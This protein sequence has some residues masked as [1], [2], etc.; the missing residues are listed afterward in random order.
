MVSLSV[1]PSTLLLEFVAGAVLGGLVGYGTK[2]IAKV[3][4]IVLSVQLVVF[5]YLE[6]QGIVVVDYDR[7][8]AG[9]VGAGEET[10]A[11]GA[12][13]QTHWFDSVLSVVPIAAGFASGFLIGYHRG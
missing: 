13:L 11:A 6:S 3:L 9:L 1:D 5:R 7:L 4:A 10:R 12:R 2:R 8:T